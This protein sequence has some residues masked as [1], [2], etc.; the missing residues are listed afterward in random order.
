[1]IGDDNIRLIQFMETITKIAD[2]GKHTFV[3]GDVR[4]IEGK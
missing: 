4:Q 3:I 1:M 2:K